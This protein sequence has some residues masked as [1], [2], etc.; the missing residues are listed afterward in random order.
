MTDIATVGKRRVLNREVEKV[1]EVR[2]ES[3]FDL[4][5]S[6]DFFDFFDFAVP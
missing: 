1:K 6:F 2:E 5:P 3:R 4:S